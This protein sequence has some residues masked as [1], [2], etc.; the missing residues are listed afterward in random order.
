MSLGERSWQA[1]STHR[2]RYPKKARAVHFS[3]I[4]HISMGP[5]GHDTPSVPSLD[6]S[7]LSIRAARRKFLLISRLACRERS[8]RNYKILVRTRRSCDPARSIPNAGRGYHVGAQGHIQPL[9]STSVGTPPAHHPGSTIGQAF[10]VRLR[11]M[12]EHTPADTKAVPWQ[13]HDQWLYLW[14]SAALTSSH[15]AKSVSPIVGLRGS[16]R[17]DGRS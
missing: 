16:A 8:R 15:I 3:T 12:R 5:R 14:P 7:G 6:H 2:N 9:S 4:D 11:P 17:L 1:F 13:E 10:F